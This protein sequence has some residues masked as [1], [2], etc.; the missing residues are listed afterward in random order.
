VVVG[1]M[2]EEEV[3]RD[4]VRRSVAGER[5]KQE[6]EQ[7]RKEKN[8]R[9]KG[10]VGSQ[11]EGEEGGR[12]C[13]PS[14]SP[15]PKPSP[16]PRSCR[17]FQRELAELAARVDELILKT[18]E[19]VEESYAKGVASEREKQERVWEERVKWERYQHGSEVVVVVSCQVQF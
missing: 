7:K 19:R 10:E 5:R 6:K 2:T 18:D 14:F 9:K 16:N 12:I 15:S 4:G 3:V 17:M 13:R 11:Q 1:E 8:K